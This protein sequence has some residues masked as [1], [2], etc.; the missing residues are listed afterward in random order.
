VHAVARATGVGS[1]QLSVA[2]HGQEYDGSN[3]PGYDFPL[4]PN[5][6]EYTGAW[7]TN[8]YTHQAWTWQ[9]INDLLA[10]VSLYRASGDSRCTQMYIE[11]N[12]TP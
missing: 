6:R 8:P 3:A 9:E 7:N 2:T 12:Y 5:Y 10:G 1:V 11:I 4:T